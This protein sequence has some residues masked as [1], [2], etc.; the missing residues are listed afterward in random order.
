M[1]ANFFNFFLRLIFSISLLAL[2][3]ESLAQGQSKGKTYQMKAKPAKANIVIDG[4]LNEETWKEAEKAQDFFQSF[5]LDTSFALTKT[6]A[7]ISYD[8]QFIYVAAIC[9]DDLP[10]RYVVQSLR[11][12]FDGGLNDFFAVY[13][14]TFGDQTNGF[15]FGMSPYGVQREGLISDGGNSDLNIDWDN[16]WYGEAKIHQGYYTVEM[17]IPFKTLRFKG[18]DQPWK[19]NFARIDRKRN[20]I[21][22]WVPVPRNFRATTLAFTGDLAFEETLKETGTNISLIP[23]ISGGSSKNHL[24]NQDNQLTGNIG[25]DLKIAV[26]SSL[27]LDL[28]FNPDFSQVEVDQQVTNLER[29]EIFFPERRQ[30]FLENNDLFARLGFPNSRPFFSRRVGIARDTNTQLIVLNPILYGARLSG[31]LNKDWRVGF[32]NMQTARKAEAGIDGQNYTVAVAQR[33]MFTRSYLTAM[34]INRQRTSGENTD[35]S[36]ALDDYDR[37]TG[38]EYNM[39]SKDNKWTGEFYYHHLFQPGEN[40]DQ[41]SHGAFLQ[42]SDPNWEVTWAHQYIGKFYNPNQVGFVP[43]TNNWNINPSFQ[44]KFYPKKKGAKV[45]N[46]GPQLNN[47]LVWLADTGEL[48][49]RFH[50]VGYTAFFN[51]GAFTGAWLSNSYTKLF[52]PFDPTNTGGL[53]LPSETTYDNYFLYLRYEA[54]PRKLFTYNIGM[55]EGTYFNGRLGIIEGDLSYRIQPFGILALTYSYIRIR[56]PQPYNNSD[57]L[58][59]GPRFDFTFSRSLFFTLFTQYNNQIENLNINARLQ[60][61]FKP[62]SDLFVVYT[63]NYFP[64]NFQVKNRALVVKLTYWLN[65]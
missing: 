13:F 33:R 28:T 10:G 42:Y 20:E 26:T 52:F 24:E 48:T 41:Y 56:L 2:F 51:D 23:Y 21:S 6:E 3:T 19:I 43:R 59:I 7:M 34:V 44:Y 17:A 64:Q 47:N 61:R 49:D 39:Q 14:D 5:P 36:L 54:N 11:R 12:D 22:T 50:E 25:A 32:L 27:N 29:F 9:Y 46:H 65:L 60:W 63:D 55:G 16:K 40:F 15:N 4:D 53:E 31:K 38:L 62:V 30:F 8:S 45:N 18:G 1:P 37:I 58:L 35:F 57:L